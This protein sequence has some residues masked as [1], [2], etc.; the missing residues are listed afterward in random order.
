MLFVSVLVA[1]SAV[2]AAADE[3]P[4]L[5]APTRLRVEYLESP[6]SIDV[7][8]PR[9]SWALPQ[10]GVPRGSV[11]SAYQLVVSTAPAV[12]PPAVVWDAGVV[13]SNR[14]LNIPLGG[15]AAGLA[16][17]MSL[18]ISDTD[19]SW[20]VVWIDAHGA[21]SA[22]AHGTFTVA[23]LGTSPNSPD[24]HGAEWLSSTSNGSLSTYRA[25][26]ELPAGAPPARARLYIA[27]LGYAKTWING[28]ITDTHELG[29]YVT[30]EER[31]LYDCIDVRDLLRPGKNVLGVMLGLGW[32]QPRGVEPG[33][34]GGQPA[35]APRQFLLLLSVT[36][37]GGEVTNFRSSSVMTKTGQSGQH[38]EAASALTFSATTGPAKT[39]DMYKGEQYD[40]RIAAALKG[41]STPGYTPGST[42]WVPAIPPVVGPA[43]WQSQVN[44][45]HAANIIQTK[46][47]FTPITPLP[48]QPA[49]GKYV[50]D[51]GQNMAGQVTLRVEGCPA[52]T[53][54][55]LQHA[56]VL[57]KPKGLVRDSFCLRPK[58][59]LCG[60]RQFANY[61]CSGEEAVEVYRVMFTSMG[62]RYVQV[63]SNGFPGVLTATS[64]TAHF[65]HSD[66]PQTGEFLSSSS[67][68][69]AIQHATVYSAASN[70]MDIPTDCPQRERQGWLGDAQLAFETVQHNFD[71][72][73]LLRTLKRCN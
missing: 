65:I 28:N 56:E 19:Y 10:D 69:N 53:V 54:I 63:T 73:L 33:F 47:V 44:A 70:Q 62:F 35:I 26:F 18:L 17:P 59:W 29:Q 22:A 13:H 61:T 39:T 42:Q 72:I 68:L 64:L 52:G 41:W 31:V 55:S 25:A 3:S 45:H 48:E 71:G 5:P 23:M 67:L 51:F 57:E 12:G 1:L 30:F 32:L 4:A 2:S 43:T 49:P 9:F 20:S 15:E 24:W 50:Y 38:S 36:A 16:D 11:Q 60:L 58:Y 8:A 66:V 37:P 46:E 14:T 21:H 34:P 7:P 6:I 27:G 40:G